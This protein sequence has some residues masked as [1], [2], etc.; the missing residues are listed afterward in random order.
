M[1]PSCIVAVAGEIRSD[2]NDVAGHW[3]CTPPEAQVPTYKADAR[4]VQ[5]WSYIEGQGREKLDEMAK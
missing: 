4:E 5:V 2:G 1:A 3:P